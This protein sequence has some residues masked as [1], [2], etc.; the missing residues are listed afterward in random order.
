MRSGRRK[1]DEVA[2][3]VRVRRQFFV[4][5]RVEDSLPKGATPVEPDRSVDIGHLQLELALDSK[6]QSE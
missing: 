5:A 1:V 2:G 4:G 3:V 6:R